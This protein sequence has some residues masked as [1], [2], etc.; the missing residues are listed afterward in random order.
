MLLVLAR[1]NVYVMCVIYALHSSYDYHSVT[2]MGKKI[3]RQTSNLPITS[4]NSS[5]RINLLCSE[6]NDVI[7]FSFV[8]VI[9]TPG[10]ICILC[11][12]CIQQADLCIFYSTLLT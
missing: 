5:S 8:V 6:Y 3:H 1:S 12:L 10:I 7:S 2:V 4:P 9:I 11:T